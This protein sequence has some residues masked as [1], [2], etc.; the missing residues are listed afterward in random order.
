MNNCTY[1]E[2]KDNVNDFNKNYKFGF[3]LQIRIKL[4]LTKFL[5]DCYVVFELATA[6]AGL[7]VLQRIGLNDRTDSYIVNNK[8]KGERIFE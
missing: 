1:V 6:A 2:N 5:S 4:K 7:N 8:I 3:N